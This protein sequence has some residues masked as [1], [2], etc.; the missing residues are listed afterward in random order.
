MSKT[1]YEI[2][3]KINGIIVNAFVNATTEIIN[4][5]TSSVT[6]SVLIN[7]Y[8]AKIKKSLNLHHVNINQNAIVNINQLSS[9]GNISKMKLSL[10]NEIEQQVNKL[11]NSIETKEANIKPPSNTTI[12]NYIEDS[13]SISVNQKVWNKCMA[14][15]KNS[16]SFTLDGG[17]IDGSLVFL[18]FDVSQVAKLAMTCLQ[19]TNVAETLQEKLGLPIV[20][21]TAT[22]NTGLLYDI[23]NLL[24]N[25]GGLIT[26]NINI[27]NNFVPWHIGLFL[28]I[29]CLIL[30]IVF[31]ILIIKFRRTQIQNGYFPY[32]FPQRPY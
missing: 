4:T 6:D 3:K 11:F 2:S 12:K 21:D 28:I 8:H 17:E 10:Q 30:I 26:D 27:F 19:Y 7:I 15:I 29:F 20:S 22:A 13:I 16:A 14:S 9:T 24:G 25:I 18:E 32:Y 5:V 1:K 23:K 31:F